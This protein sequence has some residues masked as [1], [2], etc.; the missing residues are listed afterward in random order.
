MP[1]IKGYC[2]GSHIK[3]LSLIKLIFYTLPFVI[4]CPIEIGLL[5]GCEISNVKVVNLHNP[6][7][8]ALMTNAI[9]V[10][11]HRP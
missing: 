10:A 4:F 5:E 9:G 2:H 8:E 11:S 3:L 7:S 1:H 6:L